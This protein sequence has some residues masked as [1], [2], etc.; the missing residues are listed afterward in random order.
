MLDREYCRAMQADTVSL[1]GRAWVSAVLALRDRGWL[2][3]QG[4][5]EVLALDL[6]AQW[7]GT[8]VP[9]SGGA[10]VYMLWRRALLRELYEA[11]V[12]DLA[13]GYLGRGPH[14][15]VAS[16]NTFAFRH[17]RRLIERL[18]QAAARE[19]SAGDAPD[20]ELRQALQRSFSAAVTEL[21]QRSGEHPNGWQ[22]A[23]IHRVT[24]SHP[25]G[26]SADHRP[27]IQPRTAAGARR[28][29][30]RVRLTTG[31]GR[32]VRP[33][34]SDS[35]LPAHRGFRPRWR[36]YRRAR[37]RSVGPSPQPGLRQPNRRVAA[38]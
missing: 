29:R 6:L 7:D 5:H 10:A 24:F 1:A 38:R 26:S 34:R 12:G 31:A 37:R 21:R 11:Q 15:V 25:F 27:A 4:R 35:V 33:G 20:K 2:A 32:A 14:P 9:E 28:Q 18:E 22:L 3:P 30:Y 17:S 23:A 8:M 16:A 36:D 19:R 13:A